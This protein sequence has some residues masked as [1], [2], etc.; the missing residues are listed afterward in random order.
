[1][2]KPT[3]NLVHALIQSVRDKNLLSEAHSITKDTESKSVAGK[4]LEYTELELYNTIMDAA[5]ASADFRKKVFEPGY[6]IEA[7]DKIS[8]KIG[9]MNSQ[10][11]LG[12][13]IRGGFR[14]ATIISDYI[15][16]YCDLDNNATILD[17]G[18]G[19]LRVRAGI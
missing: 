3:I 9:Y 19:S 1:M 13:A 4:V 16:K 10:W 17:F 6:P 12:D 11:N 15:D 14:S 8:R 5:V 7:E 18:C 2:H